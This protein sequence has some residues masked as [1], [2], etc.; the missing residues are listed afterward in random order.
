[1]IAELTGSALE[2]EQLHKFYQLGRTFADKVWDTMLQPLRA[3]D[4]WER[5][6]AS[7]SLS[8]EAWRSFV[9]EPLGRVVERYLQS[10]L[11]RGLVFTDAKIGLFTQPDD[12][13][14]LQNRC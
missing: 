2:F 1:S 5:E 6:F 11:V 14:F 13:S 8:R 7:D 12:E 4:R 10:D 9:E 3:K